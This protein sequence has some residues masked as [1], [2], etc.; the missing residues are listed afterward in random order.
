MVRTVVVESSGP[1]DLVASYEGGATPFDVTATTAAG[2]TCLAVAPGEAEACLESPDG[3]RVV[4]AL[5][6]NALVGLAGPDVFEV[7][8]QNG[9][10][11]L[12]VEVAP[13][14]FAWAVPFDADEFTVLGSDGDTVLIGGRS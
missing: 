14:V 11:F 13:E 6:G 1:A 8:V 4:A 3:N 5:A 2:A 9:V 10:S 12:P 7:N